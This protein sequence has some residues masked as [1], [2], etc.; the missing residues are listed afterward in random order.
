MVS[1][2]KER[3]LIKECGQH[4]KCMDCGCDFIYIGS[5]KLKKPR[6]GYCY[7]E[8]KKKKWREASEK[9]RKTDRGKA[10]QHK[11]NN[12]SSLLNLGTT[13]IG[14]HFCGDFNKEK[15]LIEKERKKLGLKRKI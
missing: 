5:G 15:E 12:K 4:Y 3:E 14:S 10:S 9:W 8:F 1:Y 7:E 11:S 2:M 13:S 6:C